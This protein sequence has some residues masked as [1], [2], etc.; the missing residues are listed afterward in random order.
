M[1]SLPAITITFVDAK[2]KAPITKDLRVSVA[3]HK[4]F[5]GFREIFYADPDAQGQVAWEGT[6]ATQYRVTAEGT[7]Y[8]KQEQ[9][10]DTGGNIFFPINETMEMEGK[11]VPTP[12][13]DPSS[14]FRDVGLAQT[15]PVVIG[16][17]AVAVIIAA[18]AYVASRGLAVASAGKKAME[19]AA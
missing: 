13:F 11:L 7:F 4:W 18:I 15:M 14:Y 17:V 1:I 6:S 12:P 16:L 8:K 10:I 19:V 2:S 5:E 3:Q 9:L